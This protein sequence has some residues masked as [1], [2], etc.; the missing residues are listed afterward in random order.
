MSS[1]TA[2]R[3]VSAR[4]N[5]R[6]LQ[7]CCLRAR[8]P[9]GTGSGARGGRDGD[10]PDVVGAGSRTNDRGWTVL[11]TVLEQFPAGGPRGSWPHGGVR[12]GSPRRGRRGGGRDGSGAGRVPGGRASAASGPGPLSAGTPPSRYPGTRSLPVPERRGSAAGAGGTRPA[13]QGVSPRQSH[14]YGSF[15]LGPYSALPASPVGADLGD[16]GGAVR[17]GDLRPAGHVQQQ[18][19]E[20]AA[21]QLPVDPPRPGP[22]V[23]VVVIGAVHAP[24]HDLVHTS[25]IAPTTDNFLG[26]RARMTRSGACPPAGQSPG[27]SAHGAGQGL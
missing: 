25:R 8:R 4:G 14:L 6:G 17:E 3:T 24:P 20:R 13:P 11:R 18:P 1:W 22:R 15:G 19:V 21:H 16:Q 2:A 12:G 26:R 9:W 7:G 27:V 23:G 10:R 5:G